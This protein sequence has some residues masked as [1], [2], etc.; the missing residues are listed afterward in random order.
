MYCKVH[1]VV[2]ESQ[3]SLALL[4]GFVLFWASMACILMPA[5]SLSLYALDLFSYFCVC[6]CILSK[7][8]R[9]S[10]LYLG[11]HALILAAAALLAL[12]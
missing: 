8:A 11:C 2:Q 12:S 1:N 4:T 5:D 3:A 9:A 7:H 10:M 6:L